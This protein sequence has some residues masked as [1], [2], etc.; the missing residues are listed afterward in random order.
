MM[1]VNPESTGD[2][3]WLTDNQQAAWR[4]LIAVTLRLPGT[5]EQQLKTD[6]NLTHF[7][8]FVLALLSEATDYTLRLTHLAAEA[9]ASLSRLSHVITR[10]ERDGLVK[11]LPCPN[12]PRATL[13]MLTEAGRAVVIAQA[14]GHVAEVRRRV[15]AG[16]ND[17]DVA[18]LESLC[19][20][21]LSQ[22][23]PPA[24]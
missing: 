23:D 17:D 9:N 15:F 5:L 12:D 4:A 19:R 14:P 6:A 7:A 11:R 8:Y 10:L 22:L 3:V 20:T 1:T 2:T 13:A 18:S 24:S 16:L 21:I